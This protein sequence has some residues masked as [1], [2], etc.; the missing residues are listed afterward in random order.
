MN[1]IETVLAERVEPLERLQTAGGV[2]PIACCPAAWAAAAGVA[3]LAGLGVG[4]AQC[5]NHGCMHGTENLL[6][7]DGTHTLPVG[8]LLQLRRDAIGG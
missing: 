5:A 3:A 4:Y 1:R 7:V 8:D 2:A 6:E